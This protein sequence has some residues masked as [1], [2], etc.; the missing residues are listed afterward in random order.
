MPV[1]VLV[2]GLSTMY[3]MAVGYWG[4]WVYAIMFDSLKDVL[5]YAPRPTFITFVGFIL[6]GVTIGWLS[7]TILNHTYY[8]D[9]L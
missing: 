7:G 2:R 5:V 3:A 9:F 8:R 6:V 1:K 4:F